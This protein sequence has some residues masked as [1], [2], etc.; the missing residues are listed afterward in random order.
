MS[1][2][3]VMLI[4]KALS[5]L[6][7]CSLSLT[8]VEPKKAQ[9]TAKVLE[10]ITKIDERIEVQKLQA[11][12]REEGKEVSL[13]TSKINYMVCLL[14]SDRTPRQWPDVANHFSSVPGSTSHCC[15]VQETWCTLGEALLEDAAYQVRMGN[16][17]R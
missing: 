3:L 14:L 11:L 9:T 7:Y 1:E 8:S 15:L 10:A 6:I 12:D 5:K 2:L 17:G 16:G 13:T 4:L